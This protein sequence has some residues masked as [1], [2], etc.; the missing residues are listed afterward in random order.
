MNQPTFNEF[1]E[2]LNKSS[3]KITAILQEL[4][5][6]YPG[7]KLEVNINHIEAHTLEK[8][9]FFHKARLEG[10]FYS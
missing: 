2:D 10:T 8:L 4:T 9:S 5:E 3:N 6:K 7:I 1:Q